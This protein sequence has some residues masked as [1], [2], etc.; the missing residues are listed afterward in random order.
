[1]LFSSTLKIGMEN[2]TWKWPASPV[3]PS[4]REIFEGGVRANA[5][6]RYACEKKMV[7][8]KNILP[9]VAARDS[10]AGAVR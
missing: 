6:A 5:D 7:D 2:G 1:M 10:S 4:Q 9:R 3:F 8:E